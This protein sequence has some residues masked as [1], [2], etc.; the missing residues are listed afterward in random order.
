MVVV[1]VPSMEGFENPI[2]IQ[3]PCMGNKVKTGVL[4]FNIKF[5]LS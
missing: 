4:I 2:Q 3:Y 5:M 1:E